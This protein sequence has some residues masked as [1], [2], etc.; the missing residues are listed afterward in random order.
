MKGA[1]I[2]IILLFFILG[3]IS[4][5]PQELKIERLECEY[6]N[7]PLAIAN[8][9]PE[10]SWRLRSD[11]KGKSQQAY[12][13]LVASSRSLLQENKGDY[14]DSGKV[15]SSNSAQVG[16]RGKPLTSRQKLYW[17]VMVWDEQGNATNWSEM[18]IWSMGLLQ[19]SDWQ[20][21]WIAISVDGNYIMPK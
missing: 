2:Y 15:N 13:V 17:K 20:G 10:L 21:K 11:E 16:Y 7:N 9:R 5:K 3:P 1:F 8:K 4:A 14:W 18:A 12:R 6:L 19:A